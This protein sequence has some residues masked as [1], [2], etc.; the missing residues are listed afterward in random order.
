MEPILRVEHL[1]HTYGSGTPFERRAVQ[2]LSFQVEAGE[3]LGVIGHTGSGKS[4]LIQHLNG[5]LRPTSGHIYLDGTDIWAKPK[6][7]RKVRFQVG[8]VFQYPEYQLFE[9]TVYRDIAFGPTNMGLTPEQVD[10]A[11]REAAAFAGLSEELLDKSPFEL[12]GGQKRRVA[13]AGV[14]AMDP[15]VL[16]LDEPTAG[17]DPEGRERLLANIRAY[18]QAK[19]N[20]ILLVSH[21]MDEIARNVDR[22]LVLKDAHVL[23]SGTPR[24]VFARAEE[25]ESAGLD[26]PQVTRIARALRDRGLAIDPAVYTTEELTAALL[27]LKK[28]GSAVC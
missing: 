17:L 25:L 12:S 26:V 16:I 11:V 14:I 20:T 1:T 15:K 7:I 9:E 21:S 13:I 23:M 4:T 8:L 2:D 24:E 27:A 5:L 3:F 10:R 28:G 19:G 22:I 18:H 6:E